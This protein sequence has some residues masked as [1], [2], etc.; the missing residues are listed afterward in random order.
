MHYSTLQKIQ[1]ALL[2]TQSE[3]LKW[4]FKLVSQIYSTTRKLKVVGNI[5][6]G[7]V[8]VSLRIYTYPN[9]SEL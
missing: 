6:G 1:K 2:N 9:I 4:V 5:T 7:I 8:P 3:Y